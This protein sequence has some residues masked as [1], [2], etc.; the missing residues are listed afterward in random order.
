[1]V[2]LLLLLGFIL[3]S[4]DAGCNVEVSPTFDFTV[5]VTRNQTGPFF[6]GQVTATGTEL[7]YYIASSP[8]PSPFSITKTDGRIF[9]DKFVD[10]ATVKREVTIVSTYKRLQLH[11][12]PHIVQSTSTAKTIVTINV[13]DPLQFFHAIDP[14]RTTTTTSQ[15]DP[16]NTKYFEAV[17]IPISVVSGCVGGVYCNYVTR[18]YRRRRRHSLPPDP[19]PDNDDD[20]DNGG[21]S[22]NNRNAMASVV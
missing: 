18:Q 17:I 7:S 14:D 8:S 13:I 12:T 4:S 22:E 16:V 21:E 1:M 5:F 20:D 15:T 2:I 6:V 11:E 19:G 10:Y 9:L 3:T